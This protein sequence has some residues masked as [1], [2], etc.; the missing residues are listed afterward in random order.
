MSKNG[1]LIFKAIIGIGAFVLLILSNRDVSESKAR[2]ELYVYLYEKY[3]EPFY[4]GEIY[5]IRGTDI[6]RY[7]AEIYPLSMEEDA[8]R[9]IYFRGG[10]R[11]GVKRSRFLGAKITAK[12]DNYDETRLNLQANEFYRPKLE[13]LFG[14]QILPIFDIGGLER[15]F[16]RESYIETAKVAQQH[17][18]AVFVKV[19]VVIFG[20][21]RTE[22]D[23]KEYIG[24]ILEFAEFMKENNTFDYI[25]F[26]F[27]V[28]DERILSEEF[29][30]NIALK[31]ELNRIGETYRNT[32][33]DFFRKEKN[34]LMD[35]LPE[36]LNF[37]LEIDKIRRGSMERTQYWS[38]Y[39]NILTAVLYSEK[40]WERKNF[41]IEEYIEIDGVYLDV[42]RDS[43]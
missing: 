12:W 11:L 24:K 37:T 8:R 18:R 21:I 17:D 9:D 31:R 7:E 2:S 26:A 32:D 28:L 13:E 3:D 20:R 34:R 30:N 29:Q 6:D 43:Y 42:Y 22:E 25:R 36:N 1:K 41:N 27:N 35:T 39:N 4:L 19:R 5:R 38:I 23:K 14:N 10:A 16:I 15:R 40:Y 33:L